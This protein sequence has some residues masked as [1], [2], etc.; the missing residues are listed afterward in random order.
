MPSRN[1]T[2]QEIHERG[3]IELCQNCC[4]FII[5]GTWPFATKF[6][7]IKMLVVRVLLIGLESAALSGSLN[8]GF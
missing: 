7:S 3:P 4:F 1:F 5:I 6:V 2:P 8:T